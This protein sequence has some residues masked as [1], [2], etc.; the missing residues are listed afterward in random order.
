MIFGPNQSVNIAVATNMIAATSQIQFTSNIS[1]TSGLYT[2]NDPFGRSTFWGVFSGAGSV[3]FTPTNG[4]PNNNT[5][6]DQP[7]NNYVNGQ[8]YSSPEIAGFNTYIGGTTINS[9]IVAITDRQAFGT[10]QLNYNWGGINALTNLTGELA[11]ANPWSDIANFNN[12]EMWFR[13]PNSIDLSGPGTINYNSMFRIPDGGTVT[14]SGAI[15]GSGYF[16]RGGDPNGTLV[17]NDPLS[18]YT[19]AAGGQDWFYNSAVNNPSAYNVTGRSFDFPATSFWKNDNGGDQNVN[20]GNASTNDNAVVLMVGSLGGSGTNVTSGPFGTGTVRWQYWGALANGTSTP[21]TVGNDF[22]MEGDM[23]INGGV[24]LNLSGDMMIGNRDRN[25]GYRNLYTS[26]NVTL[27]GRLISTNA[28]NNNN[29][30][31]EWAGLDLR[32]GSGGV[33]TL[34]GDNSML[35]SV[36]ITQGT[37]VAASNTAL[38]SLAWGSFNPGPVQLG[39]GNTAGTNDGTLGLLLTGPVTVANSISVNNDGN[40]T[41]LGG[42]TNN[43]A[44]FSGP[45]SLAKGV[46]IAS[47]ATGGNTLLFSGVIS[48]GSTTGSVNVVGPGNV[49]FA[50]ANTYSGPT[51]LSGGLLTLDFSQGTSPTSNIVS[52]S[53]A[54]ILAGGNLSIVPNG[55]QTNSQ[56]FASTTVNPGA[57]T[58][59]VGGGVLNLAAITRNVGG[60][61]DFSGAGTINTTGQPAN[62]I[63]L[64]TNGVAYATVAGTDWAAV[65]GSGAIVPVGSYTPST[66]GGSEFV[67][68]NN[69][70]VSSGVNTQLPLASGST[71]ASLRFNQG[72]GNTI[73]VNGGTLTTG[74]ILVTPSDGGSSIIDSLGGGSL[75]GP[76]AGSDLVVIQNSSQPFTISAN[77]TR[78]GL[79]KSGSGALVLGGTNTYSGTTYVNG[80]MLQGPVASLPTNIV[81][82]HNATVTINDP[83]SSATFNNSI[84]GNGSLT[85]NMTSGGNLTLSGNN[86]YTGATNLVNGTLVFGANPVV[87]NGFGGNGTNWT[88]N[89]G[90]TIAGN[91]LTLTDNN[92]NEARSAYYNTPVPTNAPF[93][94]TFTY[95]LVNPNNPADGCAFLFQNAG[96][97][98][99]G[100]GGGDLGMGGITPSAAVE[101][102]IYNGHTIGTNYSGSGLTAGN[103]GPDY[104]SSSPVNLAGGDPINVR[105]S[106]DGS[107]LLVETLTDAS[108][109]NT[110]SHTFTVGSLATTTGGNTAYVGFAGGTGGLNA[111]QQISNFNLLDSATVN[112]LPSTTQ[113]TI[114]AN[115]TLDLNGGLQTVA[116]LSD[117]IGG[118]AVINNN[119]TVASILTLSPS[120]GATSSFSGTIAGGAGTISLVMNGNGTQILSGNNIFTGPTTISAGAIQLGNPNALGHSSVVSVSVSQGLLFGPGVTSA[121]FNILNDSGNLALV[122]A[123]GNNVAL[124]LTGGTL[125]GV[126]SDNGTGPGGSVTANLTGNLL[127]QNARNTYSGPTTITNGTFQANDGGGLPAASALTLNNAILQSDGPAVFNRTLSAVATAPGSFAMT[128]ASGFAANGGYFTVNLGGQTPPTQL[129]W[130]SGGLLNVN[131]LAFGSATGNNT[132]EFQNGIDLAGSTG[133]V[134]VA[135]GTGGDSALMSGSIVDSTSGANTALVK[136]GAGQ[137][138]LSGNNQ[139]AGGVTIAAG[140][141]QMA[142][143]NALGVAVT[144]TVNFPDGGMGDLQLNGYSLSPNLVVGSTSGAGAIIEN[145][146]GYALPPAPVT[147]TLNPAPDQTFAGTIRNGANAGSLSLVKAGS[148]TLTL[149]GTNSF[150]GPVSVPAGALVGNSFSLPTSIALGS[151]A[152]ASTGSVTFN[153]QV[154]GLYSHTVSGTGSLTKT[155]GGT[156]VLGGANTY[157]GATNVLSGTLQIGVPVGHQAYQIAANH[158]TGNQTGHTGSLGYDFTVNAPI[159]ITQ[160]GFYDSGLDGLVNSHTVDITNQNNT[161][162]FATAAIP[163]GTAATLS[164]GYRFV[165]L[166]SPVVLAPGTYRIWGYNFG[167]GDAD[168]NDGNNIPGP[169]DPGLGN[170]INFNPGNI[171]AGYWQ[172]ANT[173][174]TNQD[175][176]NFNSAYRY[177]A[178]SFTFFDPAVDNVATG[179]VPSGT[180][181]SVAAGAT[182][183]LSSTTQAVGS[184]ADYQGSGGTVAVGL[185]TLTVGGNGASTTFSGVITGAGLLVKTGSGTLSLT[186]ASGGSYTGGT[187]INAGTLQAVNSLG[188]GPLNINNAT[189]R[190]SG[191]FSV[192]GPVTLGSANSTISVDLNQTLTVSSSI[193]GAGALNKAG[194]GTLGLTAQST[195]SGAT[196]ISGGTLLLAPTTPVPLP[197]NL[198]AVYNFASSPGGT[199]SN[200]VSPGTYDGTLQNGALTIAMAGAP[201]GN[202][203]ELGPNNGN[204]NANTYLQVPGAGNNGIPT[205]NGVYTASAWFYGLYSSST[206]SSWRTLFRGNPGGGGGGGSDHELIINSGGDDLGFYDNTHGGGFVDS[207]YNISAYENLPTWNQITVVANGTTST[208]Y[209][210]GQ[211]VGTVNEASTSGIYAIGSFQ[212]NNQVFSQYLANVYIYNN[213]ALSTVRVM[214]LYDATGGVPASVLPAATTVMLG[215]A[216]GTPTLDLNGVQQVVGALSDNAGYTNGLVTNSSTNAVTL[217]L[218]PSGG[219]TSTF[220]GTIQ[221]GNGGVSLVLN[222]M[223]TQVLAGTSSYTGVTT[224]AG[225]MVLA[226]TNLQNGLVNSSIGASR[227]QLHEP[228]DRRRHVAIYRQRLDHRPRHHARHEHQ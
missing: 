150:S 202:A 33:V 116:G 27:S 159:D 216:S 21:L 94:A 55:G 11:V 227:Q 180:A 71:I 112:V 184:L 145:A 12:G 88:K 157:T 187:T 153:Q 156:L 16:Q 204:N 29:G 26:G 119:S 113:L 200:I 98:A 105:L 79:T 58:V 208:Y 25:G 139:F 215:A 111:L 133:T 7:Y 141:V 91:V 40:G 61:V 175:G 69:I 22:V 197:S 155:G 173:F 152:L 66:A 65:N 89:G 169:T 53:S 148:N 8:T 225:S 132:V 170:E 10:G 192:S 101:F 44:T 144:P 228:G 167:N 223:G 136:T 86:T 120:G 161:Q 110:Y 108:N 37:L 135:S 163:A 171:N 205:T 193:S 82:S 210:N 162:T 77:I 164:D 92:N 17:L 1:L 211:Q 207:G 31:Y 123:N 147:L 149:T 73:D 160:L 128:G 59:S 121:N 78:G 84:S 226:V 39:N 179:S 214:Q 83:S 60:T 181:L 213:T 203:L 124:T 217:T 158:T 221:D 174:P 118:G 54:L 96:L 35:S 47:S 154:N 76:T 103:G 9:T 70:D 201:G 32:T 72:L 3:A 146:N 23:G 52:G 51:T 190:A 13:G 142:S 196:V 195:Y 5:Y 183:D 222:G 64:D 137:L 206:A 15:S 212:G 81:T 87:V 36:E 165:T 168:W 28:W 4:N 209:I 106:Y 97:N 24:G 95:Q 178:V 122:N 74:G 126:L 43:S 218:T 219:V 42:N 102:D 57:S 109:G 93:V 67:A 220:S 2:F 177:G 188:T 38:G 127:V 176:D 46:N 185:G 166:A 48:N 182:F 6:N 194:A 99:L 199:V 115:A 114:S 134:Q 30:A 189:F 172:T 129:T 131:T 138:T 75:Q 107:N 104:L 85:V 191:N 50:A 90:P 49:T 41:T 56:T 117:G 186:G 143:S 130:G 34:S 224:I 18:T 125:S 100:G 63:L 140:T 14:I 198:T 80:G 151:S 45:I 20:N 19:G 68:G 62:S